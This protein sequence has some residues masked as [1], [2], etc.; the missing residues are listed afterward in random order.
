MC[1]VLIKLG[2]IFSF[3][4]T[5]ITQISAQSY[6]DAS[7]VIYTPNSDYLIQT[8]IPLFEEKYHVNIELVRGGTGDLIEKITL[9]QLNPQADLLFG[10]SYI[11]HLQHRHLFEKYISKENPYVVDEFKNQTGYIT[12]YVI[13]GSVFVVNRKII[14]GLTIK[15][16]DDLLNDKLIDKIVSSNPKTSSSAYTH[17]LSLVQ[18]ENDAAL[19]HKFDLINN[20]FE[21]QNIAIVEG[22]SEVIDLVVKGEKA[23]GL[24]YEELALNHSKLN[25][26]L[27][28]V[29]PID[30]C[31]FMPGCVSVVRGAPNQ[32][33][34]Q[35]F[36]DFLLSEEIQKVLNQST[37]SRPV[38]NDIELIK[39]MKNLSDLPVISWE[40]DKIIQ[41]SE[42]I[43]ERLDE[44]IKTKMEGN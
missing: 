8:V 20:L 31:V 26:D 14:Q 22:S 3:L 1:K 17:I 7:L 15:S 42:M 40:V 28:I 2:L 5:S 32:T 29:Y 35:K 34:A 10:G 37:N 13:D 33:M 21:K 18:I 27:E 30:G 39:S 36:I 4:I 16:Y 38:R 44:L 19:A 6:E 11:K 9:D 23:V 41:M 12:P 24:T 25:S 43:D